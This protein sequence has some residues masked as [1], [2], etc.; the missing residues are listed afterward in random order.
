[1]VERKTSKDNREE[2]FQLNKIQLE[3]IAFNAIN[4]GNNTK[5]FIVIAIDVDDKYWTELVEYLIPGYDWNQFRRK[6][7]RPVARGF[8]D[9]SITEYLEKVVPDLAPALKD[10][11]PE[12]SSR[13]IVMGSGGASVYNI[14][15]DP[16]AELN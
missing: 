9:S 13:C 3:R 16:H 15:P 10:N 7:E 12:G 8:V 6:G 2:F 11:L 5:D 1:M 4:K 14:K